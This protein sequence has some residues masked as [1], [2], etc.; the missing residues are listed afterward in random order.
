MLFDAIFYSNSI[1]S[2]LN[3]TIKNAVDSLRNVRNRIM[4]ADK[5]RLTDADFQT[6]VSD[7]E[8]SFKALSLPTDGVTS[9]KSKR[10]LYKS[11]EILP[12]K[13][14]HEVV[15]RS[16]MITEITQ[17]LEKL[18]NNNDGK[19]SYFFI[20]GNPG[21]GKSQLS[22]QLGE[23]FYNGID[24]QENA[25]FIMTFNGKNLESSL[26]VWRVL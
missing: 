20:S 21:S 17:D 5:A 4:H 24:W 14:T 8:N 12:P 16:Q 19:L 25:A 1:G 11:F 10:N 23:G 3:P 9:I 13:P 6:I 18:R 26:L 22:R 2:T 7:V 15:I